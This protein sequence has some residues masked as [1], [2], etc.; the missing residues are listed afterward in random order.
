MKIGMNTFSEKKHNSKVQVF[1][2]FIA[3]GKIT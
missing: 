1:N 3:L 2:I